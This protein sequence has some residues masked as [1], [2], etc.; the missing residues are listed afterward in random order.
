MEKNGRA[1]VW[2]E[3]GFII[4]R[5]KACIYFQYSYSFKH[6]LNDKV[7]MEWWKITR[8]HFCA[9]VTCWWHLMCLPFGAGNLCKWIAVSSEVCYQTHCRALLNYTNVKPETCSEMSK[10][11]VQK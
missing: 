7:K 5:K 6:V 11:I 2:P 4:L 3:M 10:A 1:D 9:A 8:K